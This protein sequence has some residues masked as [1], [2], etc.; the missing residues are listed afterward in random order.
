MTIS[1]ELKKRIYLTTGII[2][3]IVVVLAALLPTSPAA[4]T[5]PQQ[6]LAA[7]LAGQYNC[8]L[9]DQANGFTLTCT[10]P[11]GSPSPSGSMSPSATP[12]ASSSPSTPSPSPTTAAPSPTISSG[13]D[14]LNRL[15]AC[16]F[17]NAL[18][19]GTNGALSASTQTIYSTAGQVVTNREIRGCVEVRAAN[20]TFRNVRIIAS[21]FW[22]VRS[23]AANAVFEDVEI[24]CQDT[25]GSNGYSNGAG[26]SV[27]LRRAEITSCENGL[28]VPGNTTVVDSWIHDLYDGGDA[29]T[30]GAQFN[31]GAANIRFEHNTID[32]R[33][34]STAA[35]IMW[36]EGDPQNH[37][38]LITRNLMAGGAYTLYCGRYGTA[39]NVTISQNRFGPFTY[40]SSSYCGDNGEVW[41]GNVRDLTGAALGPA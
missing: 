15:A 25:P 31:Q 22:A 41:T 39:V 13:N 17:P 24:S 34:R 9:T 12:T 5:T 2:G 38:V 16:G 26:G 32:V 1:A 28:N 27:T 30:D 4:A 6:A 35:I 10:T 21:C 29:H 14:C 20:V 7:A 19:T 37:D 40:G 36:D 18:N 3:V 11:G 8:T 23:F 33:G